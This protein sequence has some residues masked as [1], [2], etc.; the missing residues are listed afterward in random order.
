MVPAWVLLK[1]KIY[2]EHDA[3]A[4]GGAGGAGEESMG[5][6][7]A[8]AGAS[9]KESIGGASAGG[10][11]GSG[12]A[13]AGGATAGGAGGSG[14][15]V[16]RVQF[17]QEITDTILHYLRSLKPDARFAN[18][19]ELSALRLLRP[20]ESIPR[21]TGG[22]TSA[23]VASADK[24]LVALYAGP[25][26]PGTHLKGG[27][28]I[29]DASKNSL[30]AIPKPP[31]H[32]SH[33]KLGLGAIVVAEEDTYRLCELNKLRDSDPHEAELCTWLPSSQQ[34]TVEV[35]RFP[36][37]LSPPN[38]YFHADMCFSYNRTI[39]C[40]VDLFKGMVICDSVLRIDG[41][42]QFRFIP[43]HPECVTYDRRGQS[44]ER[45][46]QGEDFRSIACVGGSIK[47]VT[48]DGYGQRPGHEVS[49]TI[50]TLSS[51]LSGWNKGQEYHLRDI[52]AS[53]AYRSLGL[54]ET[55]PSFPVL[56]MDKGDVV[57]LVVT[58]WD[59][60]ADSKVVVFNGQ[61]LLSVDMQHKKVSIIPTN[62]GQLHS[63]LFASEC[64]AYLQRLE[65]HQGKFKARKVGESGKRVVL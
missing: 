13:T 22:I 7:S 18:P 28:L 35:A 63:Q 45:P 3:S 37:E 1:R 17:R 57:C 56:S 62:T 60:T 32:Y 54:S 24:N 20:T 25:Y 19:P 59:V 9:G 26:R 61:H 21:P 40:W 42:L 2:F 64:S 52:W 65:D 34:W 51:D 48:M 6:A 58:H 39:L 27:Y 11:G 53:E 8:G 31:F 15:I 46:R 47:F 12:G 5:G 10:A 14:G 33:A 41:R 23:F 29:Y 55:V 43:F 49:L 16:S 50:W 36:P 30:S 38:Y 4:S 44:S